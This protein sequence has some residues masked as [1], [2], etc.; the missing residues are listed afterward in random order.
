MQTYTDLKTTVAQLLDRDDLATL[1][2]LFVQLVESDLQS[3][4]FE[5]PELLAYGTLTTTPGEPSVNLL[6]LHAV[7]YIAYNGLPLSYDQGAVKQAANGLPTAYAVTG[8][9]TITLFPTPDAAYVLDVCYTPIIS[10]LLMGG[11]VGETTYNWLLAKWPNIYL[12]GTLA[13][14]YLH[15]QDD[16]KFSKYTQLYQDAIFKF[17]RVQSGGPQVTVNDLPL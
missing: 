9:S 7:K 8:P 4:L 13:M 10:P 16:A 2:P 3:E 15:L 11:T 5:A 6:G 1:L 12:N 17:R 14:A